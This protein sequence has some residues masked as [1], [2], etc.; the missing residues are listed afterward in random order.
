[1][2]TSMSEETRKRLNAFAAAGGEYHL[3]VKDAANYA[4]TRLVLWISVNLSYK[5]S[6]VDDIRAL[7]TDQAVFAAFDLL[8]CVLAPSDYQGKF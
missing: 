4:G 3:T 5:Q 1:M 2:E 8:R 6:C 7:T